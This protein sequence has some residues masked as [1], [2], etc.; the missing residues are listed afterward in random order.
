M[1]KLSSLVVQTG[2]FMPKLTAH[3]IAAIRKGKK[4]PSALSSCL[5]SSPLG[6][7]LYR[8]IYSGLPQLSCGSIDVAL[9]QHISCSLQELL[10]AWL[11]HICRSASWPLGLYKVLACSLHCLSCSSWGIVKMLSAFLPG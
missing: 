7:C 8:A 6:E 4:A 5:S 3:F 11:L 9:V 2:R 1:H 10:S